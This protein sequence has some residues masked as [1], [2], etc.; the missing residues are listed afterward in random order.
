[1]RKYVLSLCVILSFIG[2]KSV[3]YQKSEI[4]SRHDQISSLK[5]RIDQAIASDINVLAPKHFDEAKILFDKAVVEAQN[6]KSSGAGNE[7]ADLGLNA[8]AKAK[9]IAEE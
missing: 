7:S 6:S 2:C 4:L 9:K 1:M 8:I 3:Y 5:E